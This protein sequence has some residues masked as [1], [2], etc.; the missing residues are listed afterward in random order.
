[1]AATVS[2]Y[3]YCFYSNTWPIDPFAKRCWRSFS[4]EM[5]QWVLDMKN[6]RGACLPPHHELRDSQIKYGRRHPL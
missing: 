3:H 6:H 2:F 1:M 4:L 5:S